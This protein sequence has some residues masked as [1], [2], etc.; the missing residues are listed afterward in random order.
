MVIF[1]RT[2]TQDDGGPTTLQMMTMS[3]IPTRSPFL[4]GSAPA[5]Q[6]RPDWCWATG[7]SNVLFNG[8][9]QQQQSPVSV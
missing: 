6:T 3:A 2:P 1:E 7:K 5:S 8:A 4:S 9:T